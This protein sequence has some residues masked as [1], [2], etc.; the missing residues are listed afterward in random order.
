MYFYWET[1]L[2]YSCDLK[3]TK[4][5]K[6]RKKKGKSKVQNKVQCS[7]QMLVIWGLGGH[8]TEG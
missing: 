5:Q 8:Y 2:S 4:K 7:K 1:E 3:K 6:E